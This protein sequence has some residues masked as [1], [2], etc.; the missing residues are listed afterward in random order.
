VL[1]RAGFVKLSS[2]LDVP[3]TRINEIGSADVESVAQ[4]YS[5]ELVDFM[6][7]V[8]DIIPRSVFE[9]LQRIIKVQTSQ[10][11][12]LPV[13][14]EAQYLKEYAQV[15]ERYLLAEMTNRASSF[16][17]GVLEMEKTV[18][19][20]IQVRKG[21]LCACVPPLCGGLRFNWQPLLTPRPLPPP[22]PPPPAHG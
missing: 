3:L 16:T 19:G 9:I 14:F 22:P 20:I 11:K 18:L 4:F 13:K 12:P 5:T 21:R 10:L 6:R 7:R 15:E 8:L 1:L 17:E 2:I